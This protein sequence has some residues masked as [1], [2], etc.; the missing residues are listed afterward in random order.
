MRKTGYV[1]WAGL[2]VSAGFAYLAVRHVRFGDVWTAL[3]SSDDWW[4]RPAT[5]MLAVKALRW[6]FLFAR[7]ARPETSA[8]LLALLVVAVPGLRG[9]L[10]LRSVFASG[11]AEPLLAS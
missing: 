10:L 9:S 3:R 11:R 6:R 8:V 1:A 5:A 2:I 7:E 4:V